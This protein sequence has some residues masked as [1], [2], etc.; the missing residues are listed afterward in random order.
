MRE[1]MKMIVVL[2]ILSAFSGGLL[3][4]VRG[5]TKDIIEN[6]ELKFV[7][8]PA[9]LKILEG[10][11]NDPVNDR[12]KI[13]DGE[14]ERS[15]FVGVFNG[16]ANIVVFETFGNGYA[17]VFGLMVGIDVKTDEF[18][19]VAVT[20]HKETPGLGANAK[21]DPSFAAQ[22][23]GVPTDNPVK[24]TNDGGKISAISGATIT[25][26]AVCLVATDASKIYKRLKPQIEEKLKGFN[27]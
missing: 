2:T 17:D 10:A 18:S 6:Q 14:S 3:A 15:F 20:V 11:E 19:S 7:K 13:K 27:K 24:V 5:G 9:I 26:R 16:N 12:F 4:A 21:D 22:F 23:K 8:G 1:M 25:S